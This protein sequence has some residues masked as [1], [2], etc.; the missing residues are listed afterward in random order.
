MT[1]AMILC[2]GLAASAPAPKPAPPKVPA[3]SPSSVVMVWK[4]TEA[5]THFHADGHY[6]CLWVGK[7]WEGRWACK[8]GTLAVEEWPRDQPG[9]ASKWA[10]QLATPT[11]GALDGSASPWT[12]RPLA[13]RVD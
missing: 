2:L 9:N 4:G 12:V 8:D 10:V 11:A 3:L 6:T 13:G 1:A 7:W 5:E